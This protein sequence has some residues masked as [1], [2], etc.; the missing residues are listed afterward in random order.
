MA[1]LDLIPIGTKRQ[2][3]GITARPSGPAR[4]NDPTSGAR[5]TCL[6][7]G[8]NLA[9]LALKMACANSA[10]MLKNVAVARSRRDQDPDRTACVCDKSQLS[11]I[12]GAMRCSCWSA[13]YVL[14][15]P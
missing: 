10:S 8:L 3:Y 7:A 12:G 14:S 9:Q 2:L 5:T 6:E 13:A 11:R 15:T 4:L 1:E